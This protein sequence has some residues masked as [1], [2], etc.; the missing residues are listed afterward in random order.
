MSVFEHPEFDQ[1]ESVHY[2]HDQAT[3]LRAIIAIHSTTLARVGA[4]AGN[5][6][7]TTS[8]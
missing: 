4:G 3:G 2:F 6:R 1:H 5:T 7:A 8:P